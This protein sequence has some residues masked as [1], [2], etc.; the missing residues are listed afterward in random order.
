MEEIRKILLEM[1]KLDENNKNAREKLRNLWKKIYLIE[2]KMTEREKMGLILLINGNYFKKR[3]YVSELDPS[4]FNYGQ[5]GLKSFANI[6]CVESYLDYIVT[7]TNEY[8]L[9]KGVIDYKS[10]DT[11][12]NCCKTCSLYVY[13]LLKNDNIDCCIIHTSN[14][15]LDKIP[16][17][18][19]YAKFLINEETPV[20]FVIDI[21]FRQ[22][23]TI[24]FFIPERVYHFQDAFLSPAYYGNFEFFHQLGN[25][26]YFLADDDNLKIYLDGFSK[27]AN[28]VVIKDKI[29]YM[30]S[31]YSN[32]DIERYSCCLK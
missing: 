1:D 24:P 21:S 13:E 16:H 26:G 20:N 28:A 27:S 29:N 30:E 15:N 10:L 4:S 14:L 32:F 8:L 7:Q 12:Y 5:E 6:D 2:K 19:V 31:I 25:K 23:L 17:F 18:F 3:V 22:F 9:T 11:Y